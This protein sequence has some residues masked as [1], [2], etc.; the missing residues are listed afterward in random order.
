MKGTWL[1]RIASV[2]L[3]LFAAGH[4]FGFL[5]FSP[6]TPEGLAVRDAMN[7]VHFP[8]DGGTYSYGGFYRGFGFHVTAY[9]LFSAFLA[10]HLG[11]L[12]RKHP[13]AIGAL[14]WIFFAVQ[15]VGL[16]LNWNYFF[17]VP[18]IFS[19]LIAICLGWAAWRVAAAKI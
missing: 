15:V 3:I 13:E 18:V 17:T 19:G 14:G 4:T 2:L 5:K 7:N 16:V 9:L 8:F 11:G 6:A 10:W 12:A 1:Y